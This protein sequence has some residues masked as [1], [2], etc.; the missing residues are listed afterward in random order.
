MT[1]PL[2]Y[3][4]F[5]FTDVAVTGHDVRLGY[6]LT[7]GP[8]A[9]LDFTETLTLPAEVPAPDPADPAVRALLAGLHLVF[10]VS[11][12]KAC[13]PPDIDA[14]PLAPADA[15]FWERLYT[16]GMGEFWY[17]NGIDPRGRVRFP[18]GGPEPVPAPI[19]ARLPAPAGRPGNGRVLVLCGGGK[20]SAVAREVVRTAG[21][22]ADALTLGTSGPQQAQA[23]AMELR[24][25]VIG[26]RLDPKLFDLNRAGAL[27]GHVPISACIAFTALLVAY[28]GGYDAVIAANEGSADEGNLLWNGLAVNHQWSKS[29][30]FEDDCQHWCRR[31]LAGG[32]VYFSL[33]RPLSELRIAQA[34]ATHPRY[35]DSFTSCNRNFR[36]ASQSPAAR[37]C[38]HCPKCVFTSLI[39]GPFMDQVTLAGIFGGD[40]LADPDNLPMLAALVGMDAMKPFE[41]VGTA[42]EARA[43]L[44][45]LAAD[46][47]LAPAAA[48]W[49]RTHQARLALGPD[50]FDQVLGA[51]HANRLDSVWRERLD[52]Y[53]HHSGTGG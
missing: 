44:G 13:I 3:Q 39:L 27:N 33:L 12:Y 24:Q 9:D 49:Y 32:P 53:L 28:L 43:A 10:G 6:R 40:F 18:R 20:D 35:F 7:G 2:S 45:R 14:A 52:R 1:R 38:G 46:R 42:T 41:C 17:S 5:H 51:E 37:W 50:V 29:L 48:D 22:G 34:F 19:S 26:R 47:R 36:V 8:G 4:R 31:H 23:A 16:E 15:D 11:Y 21:V 30:I 25:L